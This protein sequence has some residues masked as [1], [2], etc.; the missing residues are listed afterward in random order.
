MSRA[1]VLNKS[2][3]N[4][5]VVSFP[6]GQES[7]VEHT[8]REKNAPDQDEELSIPPACVSTA[9]RVPFDQLEKATFHLIPLAKYKT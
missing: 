8:A 4:W 3:M 1:P 6:N 9:I 5:F 2:K 7:G